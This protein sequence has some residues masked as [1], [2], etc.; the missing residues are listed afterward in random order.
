MKRHDAIRSVAGIVQREFGILVDEGHLSF[1]KAT[2]P[3][4]LLYLGEEVLAVETEDDL[5]YLEDATLDVLDVIRKIAVAARMNVMRG[6]L[7]ELSDQ[8]REELRTRGIEQE[9]LD[10]VSFIVEELGYALKHYETHADSRG[11]PDIAVTVCWDIV[12][13]SHVLDYETVPPL[14]VSALA[15]EFHRELQ[16]YS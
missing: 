10:D 7:E 15:S 5:R 8:I 14:D 4:R 6:R 11:Y 3:T 16:E 9:V 1:E 12:R 13:V 2:L